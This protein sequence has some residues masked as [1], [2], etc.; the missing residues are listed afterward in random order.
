[1]PVAAERHPVS[2]LPLEIVLDDGDSPMPTQV[3]SQ[4]QVALVSA[5]ISASG[6]VERGSGDVE[7]APVRVSLPHDGIVELVL[8]A[9]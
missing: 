1:M 4:L 7:T 9:E 5:R 8:G 6:T 2:A 3:L